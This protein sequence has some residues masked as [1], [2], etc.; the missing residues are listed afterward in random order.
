MTR[1]PRCE[2]S[3]VDC[4]RACVCMGGGGA[5]GGGGDADHARASRMASWLHHSRR[6]GAGRAHGCVPC[7]F[8][9]Q[10]CRWCAIS[11][12]GA[13]SRPS[14]LP[15]EGG[16]GGAVVRRRHHALRLLPAPPSCTQVLSSSLDALR[17]VI[18]LYP[19][20][21]EAQLDRLMPQLFAKAAE[22]KDHIRQACNEALAGERRGAAGA[23]SRGARARVPGG[24]Q[25]R[26]GGMGP[27]RLRVRAMGV[28]DTLGCAL[29]LR[30][31]RW[32]LFRPDDC[33]TA[34]LASLP[35]P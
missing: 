6:A 23:Q 9:I 18:Q 14:F 11:P 34:P 28:Y 5:V 17:D 4:R 25:W 27:P 30:V 20:V 10:G 12:G 8:G 24:L 29:G 2:G 3:R 35:C 26:Q 22:G 19:R 33:L 7:T 21:F 31:Q 13:A 1:T 32:V 16:R 15:G